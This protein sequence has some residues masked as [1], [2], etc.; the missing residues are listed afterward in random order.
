ME[1]GFV[2]FCYVSLLHALLHK[3]CMQPRPRT[4]FHGVHDP[5]PR[6]FNPPIL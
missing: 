5:L 1:A 2:L 3:I 4:A 6:V